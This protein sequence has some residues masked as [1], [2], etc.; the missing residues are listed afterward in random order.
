MFQ[1]KIQNHSSAI[2]FSRKGGV[3]STSPLE[4]EQKSLLGQDEGSG[5]GRRWYSR[6]EILQ[7]RWAQEWRK[8]REQ[9]E[10]QLPFLSCPLPS[11]LTDSALKYYWED[12]YEDSRLAKGQGAGMKGGR[13]YF[14]SAAG[15][16]W[17]RLCAQHSEGLFVNLAWKLFELFVPIHTIR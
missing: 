1:R 3:L 2:S 8:T 6:A 12:R 17:L 11:L 7:I 5:W 13:G 15:R 4:L 10:N 9:L 16:M 14:R